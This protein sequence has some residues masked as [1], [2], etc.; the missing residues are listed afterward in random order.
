MISNKN[1]SLE[2][3]VIVQGDKPLHNGNQCHTN[4]TCINPSA[5]KKH[6]GGAT[7]QLHSIFITGNWLTAMK[8][9]INFIAEHGETNVCFPSTVFILFLFSNLLMYSSSAD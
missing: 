7:E 6:S 2:E 3:V 1:R 9:T 8:V 4:I 5:K